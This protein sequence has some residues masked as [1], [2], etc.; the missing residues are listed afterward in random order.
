MWEKT[1]SHHRSILKIQKSVETLIYTKNY[2]FLSI[3]LNSISWPCPFKLKNVKN[4]KRFETEHLFCT[5]LVNVLYLGE[6]TGFETMHFNFQ[7]THFYIWF[8]GCKA[9]SG[10]RRVWIWKFKKPKIKRTKIKGTLIYTSNLLSKIS[11]LCI[12]SAIL[13][14]HI[15]YLGKDTIVAKHL[16]YRMFMW[17]LFDNKKIKILTIWHSP[18]HVDI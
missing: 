5:N 9:N 8:T 13:I 12:F 17:V 10:T 1:T 3:Y 15:F 6:T 4:V 14:T 16:S 11:L 18:R 7:C 2:S